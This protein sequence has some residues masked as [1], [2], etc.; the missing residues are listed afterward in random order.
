LATY[1]MNELLECAEREVQQR[2]WVYP[3]RVEAKKMTQ[4][5]ATREIAMMEAIAESFR[6]KAAAE[7]R[8]TD[9]L[10]RL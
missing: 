8:N 10:M 5:R 6:E 3:R 7:R 2:K 9:L 4:Q 1:S